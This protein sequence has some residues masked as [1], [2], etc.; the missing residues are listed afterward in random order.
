[1]FLLDTDTLIYSLKGHCAVVE[2]FRIH[3]DAPKAISVITYG[4]ML[5]GAHKSQRV[6]QN[7]AKV[8]HLRELFPVIEVSC[9][10]METFGRIKAEIGREGI[11]VDDFDLIIGATALQSGYCVVT[12]NVR[13][14]DHIPGLSV[15][16]WTVRND[17][18]GQH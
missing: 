17:D 14:F 7:L 1:M 18:A 12:N 6:S 8:Q 5:H 15:V 10:V 9:A 13:N 11:V 2:N 4:E 16:N 3:A